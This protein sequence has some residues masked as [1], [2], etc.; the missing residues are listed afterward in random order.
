ML[1]IIH[2]ISKVL[3]LVFV[4]LNLATSFLFTRENVATNF[5]FMITSSLIFAV[6]VWIDM[7]K[8]LGL[9]KAVWFIAIAALISFTSEYLGVNGG[10]V[11]GGTYY[12]NNAM[13]MSLGGV[14][15]IVIAMWTAVV[16][17]CYRLAVIISGKKIKF[18]N[19]YEMFL[20]YLV[21]ALIAGLAAVSWDLVWD[22][23]AVQIRSWSWYTTGPYFGIPSQNFTGWIVVVFLSCLLFE[24]TTKNR[25]DESK[26]SIVPFLGYFYL[27]ASTFILAI[28][29]GE[30]HFALL[31]FILM[32][33]Y[34]L[35]II[36]RQIK[37]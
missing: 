30:P 19:R 21:L 25:K 24:S 16:Y 3:L 33:P 35:I 1:K 9:K 14:P 23:L 34:L 17:V 12:Y 15:L 7:W 2:R 31:S 10:T 13:G 32:S 18:K 4:V 28:R 6:L 27:L 8:V 36:L 5:I 22:P 29:L 37:K 26:D 11:F 20:E